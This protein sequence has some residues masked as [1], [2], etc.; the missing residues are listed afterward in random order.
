MA[1]PSMPG[2]CGGILPSAVQQI[3]IRVEEIKQLL[4]G[5]EIIF[6]LVNPTYK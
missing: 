5:D 1:A 3:R 2:Q 4:F 6:Y